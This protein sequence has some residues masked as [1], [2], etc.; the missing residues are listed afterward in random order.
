MYIV[1][2]YRCVAISASHN[3][4]NTA[5][6]STVLLK[7]PFKSSDICDVFCNPVAAFHSTAV[8]DMLLA[9]ECWDHAWHVQIKCQVRKTNSSWEETRLSRAMGMWL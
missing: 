9:V 1:Y 5:I 2:I 7:A 6:H 8:C 3:A 4:H